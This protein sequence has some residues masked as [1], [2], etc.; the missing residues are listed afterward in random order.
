[1][2]RHPSVSSGAND[3]GSGILDP[4]LR[5]ALVRAFSHWTGNPD[6]AED[7]AQATLLEGWRSQRR[8]DCPDDERRWIF[9]VARNVLARWHRDQG[10]YGRIT[11]PQSDAQFALLGEDARLDE[12]LARQELVDLLADALAILPPLSRQAL[13]L[14]YVEELP[15]AAI[16]RRLGISERALE[17]RLHRGKQALRTHLIVDRPDEATTLGVLPDDRR[18]ITTRIWCGACGRHRLEGRWGS[19][20]SLSL[21]CPSCDLIGGRRSVVVRSLAAPPDSRR[22]PD[23]KRRSF[24][25]ACRR[26]RAS[27]RDV[28]TAGV[29]VR[30]K[31]GT[32][33]GS[34]T[35]LRHENRLFGYPDLEFRCSRCQALWAWSYLPSATANHPAI[36]AFADEHSRVRLVPLSNVEHQGRSTFAVAWECLDSGERITALRDTQTLRFRAIFRGDVRISGDELGMNHT[37]TLAAI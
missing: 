16:A 36:T 19:D 27:F 37:A 5:R 22:F 25:V 26:L 24:R 35:I 3:A 17:G 34:V 6:E 31:C 18:W 7:L 1:M 32:C 13:L 21:D 2:R 11:L 23:L 14:R 20:G 12:E 28:A 29:E 15:Q 4:F 30:P 9:G 8:P 33:G 10:R